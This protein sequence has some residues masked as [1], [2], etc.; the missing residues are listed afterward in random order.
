[1]PFI[2]KATFSYHCKDQ[3]V[4]RWTP[5][6]THCDHRHWIDQAW[7]VP[8]NSNTFPMRPT[9]WHSVKASWELWLLYTNKIIVLYIIVCYAWM[10]PSYHQYSLNTIFYF[11]C[12]IESSTINN[13]GKGYPGVVVI[14]SALHGIGSGFKIQW[15]QYCICWVQKNL[16]VQQFGKYAYR[17]PWWD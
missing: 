6:A 12:F 15:S 2:W 3:G 7:P 4:Y 13:N 1:M 17:L 14:T 9:H 8:I 5:K 11:L 10:I 16:L